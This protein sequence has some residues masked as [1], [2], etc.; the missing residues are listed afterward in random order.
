MARL[1]TLGF[2]LLSGA[3]CIGDVNTPSG[4]ADADTDADSDTDTDTDGDTDTDTDSDTDT[5]ADFT[6]SVEFLLTR[7]TDTV[8]DSTIDLVGT[9]FAGSCEGCEF[10]F[11]IDATIT[12]DDNDTECDLP[13]AL[14]FV[15]SEGSGKAYLAFAS[16]YTGRDFI[17][18]SATFTD[19]FLSGYD[20]DQTSL[21]W[22]VTADSGGL[23]YGTLTRKG[24]DLEWSYY[25]SWAY[26]SGD[27]Y[28][29]DDSCGTPPKSGADE[30]LGGA[31]TANETLDCAGLQ[32]DVWTFDTPAADTEVSV[33]IDTVG[34][35]SAFDPIFWIDAPDGCT[36]VVADDNFACTFAP[37]EFSCPA[38]GIFSEK[39]TH[40]IVVRSRGSCT[41]TSSDYMIRVG[42][43][44]SLTLAQDDV[45][46][47]EE[48]SDITITVDGEGQ[49]E[50]P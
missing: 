16:A 21:G 10:A 4:E 40:S 1:T 46:A 5:D 19:A 9:T 3:G 17:G 7:G 23:T 11:E 48:V 50:A 38:A 15:T 47:W 28:G 24:D 31:Q 22:T 2:L 26:G 13:T 14:T 34:A 37:S 25:I 45:D 49:I 32:A 30:A 39:G 42:G 18:S 36:L 33:T 43:V 41:G 6:G 44:G 27:L 20:G 8:C 29:Y 35:G 12:R